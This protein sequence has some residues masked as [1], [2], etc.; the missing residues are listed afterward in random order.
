MTGTKKILKDPLLQRDYDLLALLKQHEEGLTMRDI[1]ILLETS[2]YLVVRYRL[3]KLGTFGLLK[4]SWLDGEK[5][6]Y[7]TRKGVR[8]LSEAVRT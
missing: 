5:R 1:F 4:W 6:F 2:D 8:F 7:I 3:R